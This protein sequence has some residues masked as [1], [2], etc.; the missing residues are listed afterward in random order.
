M[1]PFLSPVVLLIPSLAAAFCAGCA[2]GNSRPQMAP[3][4]VPPEPAAP[5]GSVD[6]GCFNAL[7]DRFAAAETLVLRSEGASENLGL[8]RHEFKLKRPDCI[9]AIH[10][11]RNKTSE[12][13]CDGDVVWLL[14]PAGKQY[15]KL[16][17]IPQRRPDLGLLP[18]LFRNAP[19]IA[20]GE[21]EHAR[22][23]AEAQHI[24]TERIAGKPCDVVELTLPDA[25]GRALVWLTQET[26]QPLRVRVISATG[27]V[28]YEVR[29]LELDV[30]LEDATFNFA[31][32][33]DWSGQAVAPPASPSIEDEPRPTP[34]PA[35][36]EEQQGAE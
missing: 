35:T 33:P 8:H 1:K 13:V 28:N 32:G 10:E 27:T 5:A 26:R 9:H 30:E 16:P 31:P 2:Q 36:S 7:I 21:H 17:L 29:A 15:L 19:E 11:Y 6:L 3:Q 4:A 22:M 14:D 23:L 12:M 20:S 34:P 18:D 24:E 25:D